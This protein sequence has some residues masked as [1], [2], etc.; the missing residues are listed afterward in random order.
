MLGFDYI[1]D[2]NFSADMTNVE[3]ATEL[4]HRL[5]D[6]NAVLLMF[7]SCCPAWVNYLEKSRPDLLPYLSS[8]KSPLAMLSSVIKNVFPKKSELKE[9]EFIM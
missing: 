4:L 9:K 3:E 1:F 6:P 5:N 7:I 2:T 8:C